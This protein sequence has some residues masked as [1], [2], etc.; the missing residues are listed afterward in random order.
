MQGS[1]CCRSPPACSGWTFRG[2]PCLQGHTVDAGSTTGSP[3][4]WV[5]L[6]QGSNLVHVGIKS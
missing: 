1:C 3:C 4:D 2:A 6:L 5:S